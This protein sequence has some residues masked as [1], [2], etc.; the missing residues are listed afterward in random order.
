M[1]KLIDITGKAISGEWGN[2]DNTGTG[3]PVLRTTN[4]TNEGVINYSNVVTRDIA[5]KDLSQKYLQ[6]GDIIIEKSGG[7]DKQPVGRVVYFDG[8]PNSYLFNN[9]TGCLRVCNK[10]VWY[11]R[12][13]FY[14][15][16]GNY[17]NGRTR[18][19]ENKTTG[20]HN[21]KTD[22]YVQDFAI[23]EQPIEYQKKVVAKLDKVTELI[24]LRKEQL[25]KLDQL[26][27][28]RFIEL[29][30]SG[31]Y[32][33]CRLGDV[34]SK[35]TDGTHKTP[36]YLDA[37]VTFISAKNIVNGELDFS[38]VKYISDQE[39]AEIQKRCQTEMGDILLSK[40]GSLG[41]PVI[42]KTT[43]RIGLFESLAV[44]KY[45]R[46]KLLPAFLCEQL[47]SNRIQRQFKVGT[48]GVAIKHLHLGVIADTDIVVPPIE[49]QNAFAAFVE[50]TDKSKLAIQQSLD[51]LETLKKS[52]MQEYF[53]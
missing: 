18:R 42:V 12:Y 23:Q 51:K 17:I 46:S 49:D 11:P 13:V 39:Y 19:Y 28:S 4:F 8:E 44:I 5:K 7:S 22:Q 40:S 2:D 6:P 3:I 34:C 14:A 35:I 10:D 16:Y 41:A 1:T 53:G 37:G 29:F 50:Q 21:L 48:K 31:N 52:L 47:K 26:V 45:D 24:T 38:D 15:L 30:E 32:P 9:F 36:N 20:L 27:K 25:A 33:V 43:E